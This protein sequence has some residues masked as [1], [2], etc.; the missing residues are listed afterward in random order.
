ML[1][2]MHH[3]KRSGR[4]GRIVVRH[5]VTDF[6]LWVEYGGRQ[7]VVGTAYGPK[8]A[9]G[10]LLTQSASK[11]YVALIK[12]FLD[13]RI[14]DLAK[15]P[16]DLG[17]VTPF[18]RRVLIACRKIPWGSTVSYAK[19]ARMAGRPRAVRAAAAVMRSN[20]FPLIVPC[21]R[22]IASDGGLG[23]FMGKTGGRAVGLKRRLLEN[24]GAV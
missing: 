14:H 3:T 24:E 15:L 13:A 12:R 7:V 10:V 23:G 6:T 16:I 2:V 20:P 18:Q 19:L 4:P 1:S 21:H 22:V 8:S 9:G 17:G 5:R 11:S